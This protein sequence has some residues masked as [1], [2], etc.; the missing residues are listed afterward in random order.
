MFEIKTELQLNFC[1]KT[2]V[3]ITRM[4]TSLSSEAVLDFKKDI[5]KIKVK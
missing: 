2:I 3:I 4:A 1:N 5:E